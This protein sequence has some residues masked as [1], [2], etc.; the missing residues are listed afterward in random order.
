MF[1]SN[2]YVPTRSFLHQSKYYSYSID[3]VPALLTWFEKYIGK[4]ITEEELYEIIEGNSTKKMFTQSF[5]PLSTDKKPYVVLVKLGEDSDNIPIWLSLRDKFGTLNGH[6]LLPAGKLKKYFLETNP[7]F[8]DNINSSFSSLSGSSA[9]SDNSSD[10][11]ENLLPIDRL[12]AD[13]KESLSFNPF[14]E[15][16]GL[17]RF[18]YIIGDRLEHF[19]KTEL[20]KYALVNNIHSAAINCG[21]INKFNSDTFIIY[22]INHANKSSG[23]SL[24][25]P[26]KIVSGR[27]T[28]AE[29]GFDA[30][31]NYEMLPPFS[32]LRKDDVFDATWIDVSNEAM[33]H[34]L[35]DEHISRLPDSWQSLPIETI[36]S[37]IRLGINR[38]L[39]MQQRSRSY[40]RPS[41]S[42]K[43][44][45]ISWLVPIT[46]GSMTPSIVAVVSKENGIWSLKTILPYSINIS[47]RVTAC[48]LYRKVMP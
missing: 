15:D 34:C 18:L 20:H 9:K 7:R 23:L 2:L 47:D 25:E 30:T 1:N 46:E 39:E 8:K 36:S 13:L 31:A 33:T 4:N 35:D 38:A 17:K 5:N 11:K 19:E 27:K 48:D 44:H 22:R 6:L 40:I 41:Y 32:F 43:L 28:L 12:V 26:Y 10:D 37:Q 29:E 24:Y 42:G 3:D 45:R 14:L 21:M 16:D